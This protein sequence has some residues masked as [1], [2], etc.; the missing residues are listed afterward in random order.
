MRI[1]LKYCEKLK[2]ELMASGIGYSIRTE[3][4]II[5]QYDFGKYVV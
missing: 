3:P 1:H 2:V 5:S 4:C